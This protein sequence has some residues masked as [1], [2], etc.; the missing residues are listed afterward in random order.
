MAGESY[1]GGGMS[2]SGRWGCIIATVVALPIFSVLIIV[3]SLGDCAPD[4]DCDKGFLAGVLLP[5]L[6]IGGAAGLLAR[7]VASY[8]ARGR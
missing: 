8:F 5:T 7:F 6:I 2:L 3:D 1:D 4:V